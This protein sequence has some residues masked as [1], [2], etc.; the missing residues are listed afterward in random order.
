MPFLDHLEEFRWRILW[1]LVAVFIG[2][3]IGFMLAWKY[4][5]MELLI[6]PA[7][8]YLPEGQEELTA[9]AVTEPF[10][11]TLKLGLVAGLILAFPVVLYQVWSFLSPALDKRERR[12]IIP[13]LYAGMLLFILGASMA[14]FLALPLGLEFLSNFQA[15]KITVI[16]AVNPYF[17]FVI[18][19]LVGFGLVFELP[20]VM[21]ILSVLGIVTPKW[22]AKNRKYAFVILAVVASLLSPGD[23]I[24]V[25]V[26]MM[27][28]LYGLYEL[29]ILLSWMVTK[30]RRAEEERENTIA[31][32]EPPEDSVER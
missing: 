7:L 26:I 14:Y 4:G 13:S 29:S 10:F 31:N 30:G 3:V 24:I 32:P 2:T 27:V 16:W 5:L 15:D 11:N 6:F 21:M 12:I 28:P 1:S 8:E 19:L 22:L 23:I 20:V 25:T 18:R 9:L 17:A